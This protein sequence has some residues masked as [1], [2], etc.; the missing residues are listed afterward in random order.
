MQL[1]ELPKS[2]SSCESASEV[3]MQLIFVPISLARTHILKNFV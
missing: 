3:G 2:M 1:D